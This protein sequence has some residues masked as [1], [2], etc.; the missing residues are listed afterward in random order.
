MSEISILVG[1]IR[2][3]SHSLFVA[4]VLKKKLENFGHNVSLFDPR[5]LNL[6]I[7]FSNV[8]SSSENVQNL[9]QILQNNI[10]K[11][12][13]VV[14]VTPEYDGSYSAVMKLLIEHLG[15]PSALA[16][17]KTAVVGV[18]SGRIGAY[19]AIEHLRAVLQH[20]GGIVAPG[21]LSL[22]EVHKSIS[23]GAAAPDLEQHLDRFV[24]SLQKFIA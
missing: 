22:S 16:G 19:R 5:Q 24:V 7:P 21:Q 20:I 3:G 17:A 2:D 23:A 14:L 13:G 6:S 18:A 12:D 4:E 10:K 9:S 15:Y 1:S 8:P 11:A